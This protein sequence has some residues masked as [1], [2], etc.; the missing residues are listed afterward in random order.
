MMR[1]LE[2]ISALL[3]VLLIGSIGIANS[4]G[5]QYARVGWWTIAYEEYSDFNDCM[6]LSLPWKIAFPDS[7]DWG[8][9]RLG[10]KAE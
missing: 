9:Q 6:S 4:A 8:W 3:L 1:R 10:S 5:T 2:L 7:G